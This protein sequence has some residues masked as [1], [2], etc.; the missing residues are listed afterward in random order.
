M[1]KIPIYDKIPERV[2]GKIYPAKK[3]FKGESLT[4]KKI[5]VSLS[6]FVCFLISAFSAQAAN[7]TPRE[8]AVVI[9]GSADYKTKDFVKT[10]TDYFKSPIGKKV[11]TGNKVQTKYQTYW[12]EK[13]LI[14]EGTPTKEDFVSFV[15]YSGYEK[16]VYLVVKD[17]VTDQHNRKKGKAL[18]RTSMTLNVFVADRSKILKVASSINEDSSKASELRAKRGAFEKCVKEVSEEINSVLK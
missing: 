17:A 6:V 13:G 12:L 8:I 2:A 11:V 7:F 1:E 18:S 5:F 15:N 16:V 3:I 10:A 4:M 14:E 9:V